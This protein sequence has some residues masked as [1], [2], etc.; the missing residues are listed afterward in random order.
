MNLIDTIGYQGPNVSFVLTSVALLDQKKYLIPFVLFY[1]IEYYTNG[2]LKRV[3]KQPRPS[4]FLD[5]NDGGN[6]TVTEQYG[7]PSGHSTAVWY[8]LTY[9]W[10]VKPTHYL[11]VPELAICFNTMYQR[12]LFKKHTVEQLVVGGLVG[13]ATAWLGVFITKRALK[14]AV[15]PRLSSAELF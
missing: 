9:L 3:F 4:G 13:G 2:V 11:L 15:I 7:M 10:L 14:G 5:K 8:S 12:W 1:F 6:Y